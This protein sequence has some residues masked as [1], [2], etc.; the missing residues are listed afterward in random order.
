MEGHGCG[1]SGRLRA[2][3]EPSKQKGGEA[4]HLFGRFPGRPGGPEAAQTPKCKMQDF[5]SLLA[6]LVSAAPMS[7]QMKIRAHMAKIVGMLLTAHVQKKHVSTLPELPRQ[8]G[9]Q[10]HFA[11]P[12]PGGPLYC[13]RLK[14]SGQ[15]SWLWSPT[16]VCSWPASPTAPANRRW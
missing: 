15:N 9:S 14:V 5:P 11:H 13:K 10:G 4:P 7:R 6:P 8:F 2:A 12:G 3:G 16:A 1:R